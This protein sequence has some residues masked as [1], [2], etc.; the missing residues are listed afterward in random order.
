MNTFDILD[1][2]DSLVFFFIGFI[3]G[4]MLFNPGGMIVAGA[5][6]V[7]LVLAEYLRER[8]IQLEIA[9]RWNQIVNNYIYSGYNENGEYSFNNDVDNI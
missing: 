1:F 3:I 5:G 7:G 9:Y 8:A 6:C 2:I 4:L